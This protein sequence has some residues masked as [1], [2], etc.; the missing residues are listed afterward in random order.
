M[1]N[2][3]FWWDS[4]S[5]QEVEPISGPPIF[6]T[7][8]MISKAIVKVRTA[9]AVRTPSIVIE[10]IRAAQDSWERNY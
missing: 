4:D 9:K 7:E 1:L 5:L 8:D 2:T 3:E 10:M 6:I